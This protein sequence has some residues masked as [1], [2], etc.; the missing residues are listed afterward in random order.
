MAA[1]RNPNTAHL[2][3]KR[4]DEG[5]RQPPELVVLDELVQVDRQQL[6]GQAQVLVVHK[7]VQ[8]AHDVVGV[9]GVCPLVEELQDGD[10]HARL[11]KVGPLVL[12]D[13]FAGVAR[14]VQGVACAARVCS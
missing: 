6:K 12:D 9:L 5:E 13:L 3:Q 1:L 8:Q 11:L 7:V 10:L 4:A 14:E 2:L